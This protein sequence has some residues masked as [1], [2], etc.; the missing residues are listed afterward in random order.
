MN[1][2]N[3]WM[4][5]VGGGAV[6]TLSVFIFTNRPETP[7]R[8]VA[9]SYGNTTKPGTKPSKK[10]VAGTAA[11]GAGAAAASSSSA[12]TNS[13]P[14]K[15]RV[16]SKPV[17]VQSSTVRK[18]DWR[19]RTIQTKTRTYTDSKG[20][21]TTFTS[22][23]EITPKIEQRSSR[24]S[25][26]Y[27]SMR[28]RRGYDAFDNPALMMM[29]G[30]YSD[31]PL[32]CALAGFSGYCFMGM[33]LNNSHPSQ[34]TYQGT[35]PTAYSGAG[36]APSY[37]AGGT[38]GNY[39]DDAPDEVVDSTVDM[40]TKCVMD[41]DFSTVLEVVDCVNDYLHSSA[42]LN[43]DSFCTEPTLADFRELVYDNLTLDDGGCESAYNKDLRDAAKGMDA[44]Q[45]SKTEKKDDGS[46]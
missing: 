46:W 42:Q 33:M 18:K 9:Q 17:T 43:I 39:I 3:H 15:T 38:G 12:N 22:R 19:G 6:L 10:V 5:F 31:N 13:K 21:K 24:F 45:K 14:V 34:S 35:P 41:A 44:F 11:A 16:G 29:I 20:R 37:V 32:M 4:F 26:R 23:R 27:D 8:H 40:M 36:S 28:S 25:D 30:M 1:W 2:K 7:Y